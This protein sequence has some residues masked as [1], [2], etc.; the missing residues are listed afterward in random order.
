METASNGKETYADV[1]TPSGIEIRY[2]WEPK[3][4]YELRPDPVGSASPEDEWREVPS[5]TT[6]LDILNKP[7]LPWWGMEQ[8]V[9][10][11][12]QLQHYPQ[13]SWDTLKL[14]DPDEIV[15]LLTAHKLTVNHVR[16]QASSRGLAVHAA[17]EGWAKDRT[18]PDPS[19][20]PHEERGYVE[21][22]VKFL[23][24]LSDPSYTACEVMVGSLRHSYAGRYDLRFTVD[25]AR[26][27]VYKH[28]PVRG[29]KRADLQPGQYML[30]LKTSKGVYLSHHRQLE[31]YELASVECGYEPTDARGILHVTADGNYEFVRSVA[32]PEDFVKVLDV[33][34]SEQRLKEKK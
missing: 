17:L 19:I 5:V 22:L 13:L 28:T 4:M 32:D 11:L 12:L 18:I 21:G 14:A 1:M 27:V 6:V 15:R 9:K 3:R 34:N 16:D 2:H 20:F 25:S 33:W 29:A 30:D 10:G 8:G 31:A 24:D 7:A 26:S 23:E